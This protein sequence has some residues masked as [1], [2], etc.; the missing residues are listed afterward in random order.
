M[1]RPAWLRQASKHLGL[2]E[3]SGPRHERKIIQ[4]FKDVGHAWVTDDET[5]WCAAFAGACLE[6]AGIRSSRAL[7][8]RSYL[9][10]GRKL[11]TPKVGCI[12]VFSRGSSAWQG[13]V[14]FYLSETK[15]SV[16]VIGGNQSNAV[17]IANYSKAKL[18]GYRW[19]DGIAK[20][21]PQPQEQVTIWSLLQKWFP[22]FF[23]NTGG[24]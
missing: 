23:G 13:H 2:K 5:A 19:P 18:L 14:A 12:V 4:F 7:N 16:R 6:R 11:T 21:K 15:L 24:Q 17:T 3:I 20:P 22:R 1:S 9:T 8:A 10:W